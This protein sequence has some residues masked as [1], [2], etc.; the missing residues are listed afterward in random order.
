MENSFGYFIALFLGGFCVLR[1]KQLAKFFHNQAKGAP[2]LIR[3]SNKWDILYMQI[4]TLL[5][6]SLFFTVSLAKLI[7]L[8]SIHTSNNLLD[9]LLA[10]WGIYFVIAFRQVSNFISQVSKRSLDKQ[11]L[12]KTRVA[13]IVIGIVLSLIGLARIFI[14]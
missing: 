7:S 12:S 9:W 14:V 2:S 13:I 8:A 6:G 1:F 11:N 4:M 5:V 10:F 3:L